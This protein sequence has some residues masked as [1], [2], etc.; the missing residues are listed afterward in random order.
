MS[1]KNK[2]RTTVAD[3]LITSFFFISIIVVIIFQFAFSNTTGSILM[4]QTNTEKYYF[5][6]DQKTEKIIKGELGDTVIQIDNGRFRF[7]SSAC[8]NKD[9]IRMGWVNRNNFPVICL[10][11]KV[12]AYIAS[13][14]K[15]IEY[16]GLCR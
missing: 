14:K 6:L 1:A 9:C 3:I 8:P 12:T 10:P 16:D 11:N 13:G 5:D 7:E 2:K 15:D 4:V